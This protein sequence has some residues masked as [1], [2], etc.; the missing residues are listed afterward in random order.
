MKKLNF[1][2]FLGLLLTFGLFLFS[3]T[4][5]PIAGPPGADGLD[6]IDGIDGVDGQD[7][8]ASCI[9]CHSNANREPIFASFA[10]SAHGS[11]S[12]SFAEGRGGSDPTNRC[13]QCHGEEGF[14]DIILNGEAA[15]EGYV[16]PTTI[17]CTTC[18]S[19]HDTFDFENDGQDYALV[20]DYAQ[21][22]RL[23]PSITLDFG[24]S[25]NNCISC[26]QPRT[27]YVIPAEDGTGQYDMATTRFGPHHGPQS[28]M[29]EG[30]LGVQIPGAEGYPGRGSATHRTGSSCVKCHMGESSVTTEGLH[31][32]KPRRATVCM[33]CHTNG[34]PD[35]IDGYAAEI[36]TLKQLLENVVGEAVELDIEGDP[37]FDTEGNLIPTGE[38]LTGIIINDRSQYGIFTT[39]Q[40]QAAWNYMTLI[41]DQS[42][43]VH[44]PAYARALLQ[45]SI[46]ALEN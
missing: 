10:L 8:T 37:V 44:N 46:E 42:R 6:G 32:W 12:V 39:I 20:N 18:H 16:N 3:C 21:S 7:G 45:N 22:L 43:G 38:T 26:H 17:Y 29:L 15:E 27:S 19:D 28:S 30:V 40:A 25:S 13:A 2:S 41:E 36:A 5:D 14:L 9:S 23:D 1:L 24:G 34:A 11:G 35:E 31:S 4:S 33:E